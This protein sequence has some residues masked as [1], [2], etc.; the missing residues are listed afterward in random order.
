M[1][2]TSRLPEIA[3]NKLSEFKFI[4]IGF[5]TNENIFH[6]AGVFYS[7]LR[8]KSVL[9]GLCPAGLGT[10]SEESA[11]LVYPDYL[12]MRQV[13]QGRPQA[14][15]TSERRHHGV[16]SVLPHYTHH[17]FLLSYCV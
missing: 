8:Q 12:Q 10:L 7:I 17:S 13:L 14:A 9:E 5:G 6:R 15:R 11:V 4:G 16:A 2:H 1:D 3:I